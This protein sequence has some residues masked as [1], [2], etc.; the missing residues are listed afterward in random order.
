MDSPGGMIGSHQNEMHEVA[1]LPS[2]EQVI[3]I[4][5]AA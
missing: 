1:P 3:D 5:L 4:N 2:E